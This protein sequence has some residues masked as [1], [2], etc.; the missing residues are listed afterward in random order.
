MATKL[1]RIPASK[2]T[3]FSTGGAP[4]LL[5]AGEGEATAGKPRRFAMEIYTGAMLAS[6]QWGNVYLD[7][8][9]FKPHRTDLAALRNHDRDQVAGHTDKWTTGKTSIFNE[10]MF[11]PGTE[12]QEPTA[13]MIERR[14]S[15]NFPYQ[16]SGR[17]Q[18]LRT[19]QVQAGAAASVN[20]QTV[21]GPC[22]IFREFTCVEASFTEMG[23]DPM[24]M[25]VTAAK[26][27]DAEVEV[28]VEGSAP[29]QPENPAMSMKL[30]PILASILGSDQAIALLGA[31][32]ESTSLDAFATEIGTAF[33][34]LQ[35]AN[36]DLTAK[37]AE[38]T[39][40]YTALAARLE[41]AKKNPAV[42]TLEA[43][44][45]HPT[46]PPAP[47]AAGTPEA[48]KAEYAANKDLQAEFPTADHYVVFKQ[49]MVKRS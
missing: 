36:K 6:W 47:P 8:S 20:G 14:L 49:K 16:S 34:T 32:P 27:A 24:T 33:S 13:R 28:T 41:E 21:Q 15:A 43:D 25:C 39:T 40:A 42:L 23:M 9:G 26:S 10:G 35:A 7:I 29:Q 31:K 46:P 37:L 44:A 45:S 4:Q 3:V 48:L 38:K 30:L 22:T 17:W 2:A 19:E 12:E 11:L 1:Q 18:P 5:A